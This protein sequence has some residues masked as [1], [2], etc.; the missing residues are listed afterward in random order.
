MSTKAS[1]ALIEQLAAKYKLDK[2]VVA[3]I[4]R[5]P[6]LFT[7]NTFRNTG[8]YT[9]IMLRYVGKFITRFGAVKKK[10]DDTQRKNTKGFS[11]NEESLDKGVGISG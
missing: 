4:V 10:K 3:H 6:F 11:S 9:P 2:R 1:D 8:D 5:Y 7:A